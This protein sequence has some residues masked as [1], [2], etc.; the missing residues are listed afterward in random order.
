MGWPLRY[1][2]QSVLDGVCS[3]NGHMF[4]RSRWPIESINEELG[5]PDGYV[6]MHTDGNW[7]LVVDGRAV[8]CSRSD[9][10]PP[11]P[12]FVDLTKVEA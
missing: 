10:G 6:E 9:L 12:V 1:R 11:S 2:S 7:F 3:I 4:I 5:R 8:A